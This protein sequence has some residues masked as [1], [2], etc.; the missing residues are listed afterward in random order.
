M[1]DT[2]FYDLELGSSRLTAVIKSV[3]IKKVLT[4][5][6]NPSSPEKETEKLFIRAEDTDGAKYLINEAWIRDHNQQIVVKGMWVKRDASSNKLFSGKSNLLTQLLTSLRVTKVSEL[7]GKEVA[8]EPK[9]NNY[10]AIV[11]Y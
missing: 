1:S 6:D 5:T 7:I 11:L 4:K 8:I 3:E 10:M 2:E 9:E